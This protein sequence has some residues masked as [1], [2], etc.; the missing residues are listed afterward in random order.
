M[1]KLATA[2]C[3]SSLPCRCT[4]GSADYAT[5]CWLNHTDVPQLPA[6]WLEQASTQTPRTNLN[7]LFYKAAPTSCSCSFASKPP[8]N[9]SGCPT[10]DR[11]PKTTSTCLSVPASPPLK[12]HGRYSS[13][14]CACDLERP[15]YWDHNHPLLP[16]TDR[17]PPPPRKH[18]DMPDGPT[19]H[20]GIL[21]PAHLRSPQPHPAAQPDLSS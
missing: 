18:Q 7:L 14:C 19:G 12:A 15:S 1:A 16:E 2:S 11:V 9:T 20:T 4:A 8:P 17:Q 21:L 5:S 10:S 3:P 13:L 6:N